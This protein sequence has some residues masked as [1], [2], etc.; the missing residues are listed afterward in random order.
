MDDPV[1]QALERDT[2]ID[3]TTTGRRTGMPRRTEIWFHYQDGR[4]F[5]TSSPGARSWYANMKADP[6]F[7][8]HF[9]QSLTRDIPAVATPITDEGERRALFARMMQLEQ[10][11]A[12]VEVDDWAKRSALVQVELLS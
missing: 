11:M 8:W 1:K 9:K 4:I 10:R 12:H 6:R 5:I 3:I 2:L 7:T